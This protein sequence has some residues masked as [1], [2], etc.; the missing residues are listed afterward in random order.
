MAPIFIQLQQCY[1][2]A[3]VLHCQRMRVSLCYELIS[4]AERNK[5]TVSGRST[6]CTNNNDPIISVSALLL[7]QNCVTA[8]AHQSQDRR[9]AS[10]H[11]A[12]EIHRPK[13]AVPRISFKVLPRATSP[14]RMAGAHQPGHYR[15]NTLLLPGIYPDST[16]I[17]LYTV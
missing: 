15:I 13:S 5:Q 7:R 3:G 12:T 10:D 9:L 11:R 17:C 16:G 8:H 1:R 6:Q 4:S 14:W 2:R